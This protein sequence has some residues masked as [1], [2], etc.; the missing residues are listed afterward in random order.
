MIPFN[1]IDDTGINTSLSLNKT[2]SDNSNIE[3]SDR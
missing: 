1:L 3:R 2:P